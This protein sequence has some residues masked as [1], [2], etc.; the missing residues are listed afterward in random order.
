MMSALVL[1]SVIVMFEVVDA[2]FDPYPPAASNC[3]VADTPYV[4]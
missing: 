4:P 3:T 2:G 1:P